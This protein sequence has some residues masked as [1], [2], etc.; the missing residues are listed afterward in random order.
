MTALGPLRDL[1]VI[2]EVQHRPDPF[3]VLRVLAHGHPCPARFLILGSASGDLLHQTSESLARRVQR[4]VIGGF[5]LG[6]VGV[7]TLDE[8]WR[9]GGFPLA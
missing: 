6:E 1:V 7:A 2:H 8:L 3:P 4:I 9:R 5:S